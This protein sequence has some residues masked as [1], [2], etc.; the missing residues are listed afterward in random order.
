MVRKFGKMAEQYEARIARQV[1]AIDRLL[2]ANA[3]Q[4]TALNYI[5]DESKTIKDA[6]KVAQEATDGVQAI[7]AP[8]AEEKK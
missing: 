3:M 7:L 5:K 4:A 6:R 2:A 8:P 1:E